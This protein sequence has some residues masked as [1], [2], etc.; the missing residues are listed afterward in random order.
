MKDPYS[1]KII[2]GKDDQYV[3]LKGLIIFNNRV[4]FFLNPSGRDDN[5][6]LS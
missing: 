3:I 6:I 5:G 1:T 4:F 2:G